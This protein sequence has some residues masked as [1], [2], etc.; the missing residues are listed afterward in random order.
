LGLGRLERRGDGFVDAL[1]PDEFEVVPRTL[2]DVVVVPLVA[3]TKMT[4]VIS[5][6]L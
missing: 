4:T 2:R 6:F 3:F 1:Q 5:E